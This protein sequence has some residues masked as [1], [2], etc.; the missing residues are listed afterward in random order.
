MCVLWKAALKNRELVRQLLSK[1]KFD[2]VVHF[3]AETHVDRSIKD[4]ALFIR[5]NV[6]GTQVLLD[7]ARDFG[8][9]VS[10]KFLRMKFMATL[11][12]A[13]QSILRKTA[14]FALATLLC[15]QGGC[16]FIV[17]GLQTY[18][19]PARNGEPLF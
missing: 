6:E 13:P 5:S 19:R 7:A 10:I 18:L 11:V 9:A 3:A 2:A 16:R 4:P 12:L 8:V 17:F 15:Q 14:L 1:E